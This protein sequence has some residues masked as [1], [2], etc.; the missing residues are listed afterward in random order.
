V[1]PALDPVSALAEIDPGLTVAGPW[2]D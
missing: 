1:V 2:E